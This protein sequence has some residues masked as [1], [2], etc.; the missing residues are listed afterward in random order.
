MKRSVD[1][2]LSMML[3]SSLVTM[4]KAK[5]WRHN[6]T[7]STYCLGHTHERHCLM[8]EGEDTCKKQFS[9]H[10]EDSACP[11]MEIYKGAHKASKRESSLRYPQRE[12]NKKGLVFIKSPLL[13]KRIRYHERRPTLL[14]LGCSC[15]EKGS[16]PPFLL[17]FLPDT[18]SQGNSA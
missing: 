17:S 5:G 18:V 13:G 12:V 8:E 11:D 9:E 4:R 1:R 14:E 6:Y 10:R 16:S 7:L 2:G 15:W 3:N